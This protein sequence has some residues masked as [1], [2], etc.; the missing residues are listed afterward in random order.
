M[1]QFIFSDYK[2]PEIGSNNLKPVRKKEMSSKE[3]QSV[4]NLKFDGVKS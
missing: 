1:N 3:K 4:K 2:G